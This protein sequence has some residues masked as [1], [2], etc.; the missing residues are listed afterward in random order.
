MS[1]RR[2]LDLS[3]DSRCEA[4]A[5]EEWGAAPTTQCKQPEQPQLFELESDGGGNTYV[6]VYILFLSCLP[7]SR[8]CDSYRVISLVELIH[9]LGCDG[10]YKVPSIGHPQVHTV[11][12]KR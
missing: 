9:N 12:P 5:C 4:I 1:E 6:L 10:A 3:N 11:E 8:L 2:D 7:A